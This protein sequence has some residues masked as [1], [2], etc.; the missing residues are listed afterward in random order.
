MAGLRLRRHA[1]HPR[2]LAAKHPRHL[3]GKHARPPS[4]RRSG[5]SRWSAW[6]TLI[7]VCAVSLAGILSWLPSATAT[8]VISRLMPSGDA[9]V[10][11]VQPQR[12]FG[13]ADKL[14]TEALPRLK[15]GYLQFD[16]TQL[17]GTV[18]DAR[19]RLYAW[20]ADAFGY[21]I[22]SVEG[23]SWTEDTITYA[24]APALGPVVARSGPVARDAWTSVDVTA[25]LRGN[26]TLSLA[27]TS[28]GA[29]S[30]TYASRES[31]ATAPQLIVQATTS[32]TSSTARTT[33]STATS[34]TVRATTTTATTSLISA[35]AP[36]TTAPRDMTTTS[37]TTTTTASS[38]LPLSPSPTAAPVPLG[39]PGSWTLAFDDEFS[40]TSLDLT[41]WS[42]VWFSEDGVMNNVGTYSANVSV[43]GGVL[44]LQLADANSGALIHTGYGPGRYQLPVGGYAEARVLFPGDGRTIYNWPGWWASG[45]NWPEAGEHDIAEGLG[46][47]TV[48]YHSPS[49]A[50]NQGSVPGTWSNAFHTYG[51]HRKATS[52][53][54]YWDGVLVKSYP[55]DDNGAG[56]SLLLNVGSHSSG[57][58]VFGAAG[59]VRVD[60][61]RA[62]R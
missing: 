52:A 8:T 11:G 18:V 61:V 43:G 10:S 60:Y 15:S 30:G 35:I 20:R 47:L 34:T 3:A 41:K 21:T 13:S 32:T 14:R 23:T 33:T 29:S 56:Q 26:A 58:N 38:P 7:L 28:T 1:H 44:T 31:G 51:L 17:S 2:H 59:Q 27:L 42:K 9:Y 45:P 36:T 39:V 54:V 40:G 55:T 46:S 53:D 57:G 5:V 24:N 49:G 6:A 48:N 25:L 16:L 19:L 12:N 22:R 50:H 37:S 4:G 62:W